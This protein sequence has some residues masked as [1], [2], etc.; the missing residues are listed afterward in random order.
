MRNVQRY[1]V[2]AA[3]ALLVA[4]C[5]DDKKSGTG[6]GGSVNGSFT[7]TLSGD[8]TGPLSGIAGHA[9]VSSGEDQGFIMAFEDTPSN[10]TATASILI[11]RENPALPATGQIT[12][13]SAED[14]VIGANDYVM[15]AV[16][17]DAQGT[18]WLCSSTGGGMNVSSSSA[19]RIRGSINVTAMC[20]EPGSD[21]TKDITIAGNFDSRQEEL[22][23]VRAM[24]VDKGY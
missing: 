9:A 19:A 15:L 4:A 20:I 24:V 8:I 13:K 3:V 21:E 10:G 2:L 22:T 17:T 18:D 12:F 5:G 23:T 16:V 1:A 14:D 7:A 11:G 6:P